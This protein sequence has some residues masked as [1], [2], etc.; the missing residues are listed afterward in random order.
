[1]IA[2]AAL[3]TKLASYQTAVSNE[4]SL[5]SYYTFD[6]LVPEDVIGPNE[7]TLAGTADWDVGI[8]GGS[9]HGLLLDGAGHVDLYDRVNLIPWDKLEAFFSRHLAA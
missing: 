9:A 2:V 4:S 6:R 5:I 7:G 3:P 1:M 8:G